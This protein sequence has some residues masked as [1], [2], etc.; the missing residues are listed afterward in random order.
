M[1]TLSTAPAARTTQATHDLHRQVTMHASSHGVLI[2]SSR[3]RHTFSVHTMPPQISFAQLVSFETISRNA[4]HE[5]KALV[6]SLNGDLVLSIDSNGI[7]EARAINMHKNT[8]KKRGRDTFL[9]DARQAISRIK[10]SGKEALE[11]PQQSYD[12]AVSVAKSL[13]NLRGTA[14]ETVVE[15]WAVSLRKD[16]EWGGNAREGARLV[17]AARLVAGVP[18]RICAMTDV[19]D[20]CSDGMI[21]TRQEAVSSDFVLPMSEEAAAAH[22]AGQKTLLLFASVPRLSAS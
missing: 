21:T 19:F 11:V 13:V 12:A 2:E 15:S 7:E 3:V 8:G 16:G 4:G 1:E 10:K 14:G 9:D 5:R 20:T 6:A 18:F 22:E 17:V